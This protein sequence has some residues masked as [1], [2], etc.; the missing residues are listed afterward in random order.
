MHRR[1]GCRPAPLK[2][3]QTI[4]TLA[5][6]VSTSVVALCLATG[7]TA[8]CIGDCDGDGEVTVNELVAGVNI[9]L[10]IAQIDACPSFDRDM[11]GNVT[12]DEILSGVNAL[13][14]G[15]PL[16]PTP[17]D[18]TTPADSPTPTDTPTPT[19]TA[20]PT[21]TE[22]AT[23]RPTETSTLTPAPTVTPIA[24]LTATLT[25]TRTST[26]SFAAT[27]TS[28]RTVTS[29][30]TATRSVTA[31]PVSVVR[32]C[33]LVGG[34]SQITIQSKAARAEVNLTGSQVWRFDAPGADGTRR[35]VSQPSDS[36]FDCVTASVLGT[37]QFAGC[38]RMDPATQ[39][40]G[41]IDCAGGHITA[42]YDVVA[43]IDHNTNQ[44]N[45]GFAQDPQCTAVYRNPNDAADGAPAPSW[46]ED[47]MGGHVH[48]GVCNSGVHLDQRGAFPA[49]G[50]HMTQ[51]LILRVF[52]KT[53]C[54]AG[55]C[56]ADTTPFNA[57]AGDVQ[58]LAAMSSGNANGV[59]FD[60]NNIAGLTLGSTAGGNGPNICGFG[61]GTDPCVTSIAGAPYTAVCAN[62]ST[63]SLHAGKLVT[64]VTALD[65]PSPIYDV[66]ATIG[67]TC[68]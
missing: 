22:T 62:P 67:I 64:A 30:P 25:R 5:A 39:G 21:A 55:L 57:A 20:P 19:N 66:V 36:H 42:G 56:P 7:A 44:N 48:L 8:A 16:T 6:F 38:L 35:I 28:T 13:L 41:V 47:G 23:P 52:E 12:V 32:T 3:H 54:T 27:A 43:S 9:A 51:S 17:T 11:D 63:G 10:G 33:S 37:F 24:S 34:N 15:C 65:L 60:V 49:G 2:E 50:V 4:R 14:F 45:T 40:Q 58:V 1:P 31:M 59:I 29:T 53:T 26:P 68:Q 18:S 46:I 61:N